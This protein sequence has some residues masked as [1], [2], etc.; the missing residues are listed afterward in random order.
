M[1][2]LTTRFETVKS[3]AKR[4]R[5]HPRTVRRW[6]EEGKV[7]AKKDRGGRCWLVLIGEDDNYCVN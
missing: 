5:K 7:K 2:E 3:L 6:I 4:V 1:A